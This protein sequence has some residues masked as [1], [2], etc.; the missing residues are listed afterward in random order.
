M[1]KGRGQLGAK[2][3]WA[4]GLAS[5]ERGRGKPR[6]RARFPNFQCGA[7]LAAVRARAAAETSARAPPMAC[8]HVGRTP[9]DRASAEKK[10]FP[11][12]LALLP[13]PPRRP[14]GSRFPN[15]FHF[16]CPH[17]LTLFSPVPEGRKKDLLGARAF[18]ACFQMRGTSCDCGPT[19]A[20]AKSP[21]RPGV[22]TALERPR[23]ALTLQLAG[24][25]PRRTGRGRSLD[26]RSRPS[27]LFFNTLLVTVERAE[28]TFLRDGT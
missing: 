2:R 16:P 14:L 6:E 4:S 27:A 28:A 20:R 13:P 7:A 18:V 24:Q 5:R 23:N 10:A 8:A 11:F 25:E 21:L 15:S 9:R 17:K 1:L 19:G 3:D 12:L 26:S 22:T